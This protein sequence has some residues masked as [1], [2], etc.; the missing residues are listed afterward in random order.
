MSIKLW[1]KSRW[2][3]EWYRYFLFWGRLFKRVRVSNAINK[4]TRFYLSRTISAFWY[5]SQMNTDDRFRK[6]HLLRE[7][8]LTKGVCFLYQVQEEANRSHNE[9]ISALQEEIRHLETV[10]TNFKDNEKSLR[11][12]LKALE[13]KVRQKPSVISVH[14]QTSRPSSPLPRVTPVGKHSTDEEKIVPRK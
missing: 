8:Q 1:D 3:V 12:Q 4:F 10:C 5:G 2:S 6:M 11:D 13:T 7:F 9:T 14:V